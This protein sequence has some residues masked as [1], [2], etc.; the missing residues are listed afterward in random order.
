M[1]FVGGLEKTDIR[2]PVGAV[3]VGSSGQKPMEGIS[4]GGADDPTNALGTVMIK[5]VLQATTRDGGV[6]RLR[7][8]CGLRAVH[9]HRHRRAADERSR[10]TSGTCRVPAR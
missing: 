7:R 1:V 2:R 9:D 10:L 8:P 3:P 4:S 6:G 5:G